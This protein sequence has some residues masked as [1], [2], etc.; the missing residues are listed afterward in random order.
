[1]TNSEIRRRNPIPKASANS[2][3]AAQ[4]SHLDSSNSRPS[5]P[6]TPSFSLAIK[7]ILIA[8]ILSTVLTPISDCDEVYNYYE[9]LHYLV[10]GKGFQTWEYSPAF[11]IRSW[12]YIVLHG[13]IATA[14]KFV[15]WLNGIAEGNG[16]VQLF[17]LIRM[18]FAGLSAY[19]EATFYRSVVSNVNP[20]IGRY[21]LLFLIFSPGMFHAS[22]SYLPST[23]AMYMVM[24]GY[25]ALLD[26]ANTNFSSLQCLLFFAGAVI[27]GWPFAGVIVLPLIVAAIYKIFRK[28]SSLKELFANGLLST[29]FWSVPIILIDYIFY[30]NLVFVP[31]NIV[32]YN[33][34]SGK[35]PDLYGTD[36]WHFYFYNGFLNFGPVWLLCLAGVLLIPLGRSI[37]KSTMNVPLSVFAPVYLWIVIFTL[38][39]HKE[40]RFLYPIYPL[41]IFTA[42][43]TLYS[44]SAILDA[45]VKKSSKS[46]PKSADITTQS[47]SGLSPLRMVPIILLVTV[48]LSVS[49]IV[50]VTSSYSAPF[51]VYSKLHQDIIRS[52][53]SLSQVNVCVGKEW[54]RFPSSFFLP[55]KPDTRLKFVRSGFRG[56]LPKYFHESSNLQ[57]NLLLWKVD[58]EG[59][60]KVP[61]GMN[62]ENK[63]EMDRYVDPST[64]DY[65]IDSS[66]PLRAQQSDLFD[67]SN[68]VR[69]YCQRF[70]DSQNSGVLGRVIWIPEILRKRLGR[71][72]RKEWGEY[73]VLK[74]KTV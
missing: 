62:D 20:Y 43:T 10:F 72:G 13:L 1:M 45:V 48:G 7:F 8:R 37:Q 67:E 38:Q 58:F 30:G 34:F 3:D 28:Q 65:F 36:A 25:A 50:A 39:P 53:H 22:I 55:D 57:A 61:D 31:M 44:I 26:D 51:G 11:S 27:F 29:A 70:L 5:Q 4:E 18:C 32:L 68:F 15:L 63:E 16:K 47:T 14:G 40:E 2:I 17:Y 33:V 71:Y 21:V 9:P 41:I 66:F 73:C 49:R 64:C 59:I 12:S 19:C 46:I 6:Y 42:A 52:N 35:G 60:R 54:Y 24:L 56:I 69:L 23:F 74:K